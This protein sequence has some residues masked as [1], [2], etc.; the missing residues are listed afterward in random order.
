M[1]KIDAVC[2]DVFGTLISSEHVTEKP[3]EI[4][5]PYWRVNQAVVLRIIFNVNH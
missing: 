3:Y 1:S 5:R 2:F 4:F